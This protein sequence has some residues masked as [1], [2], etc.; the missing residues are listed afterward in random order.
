MGG[1]GPD[2]ARSRALHLPD[3][4]GAHALTGD[5]DIAVTL[6]HQA[7]DAVTALSSSRAYDR[8]RVLYTVLEPMYTSGGVAELRDRLAATAV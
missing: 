1:F 2:R 3:L 5:T 4:A 6:G 8:L 7:V